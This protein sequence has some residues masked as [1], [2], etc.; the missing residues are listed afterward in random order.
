MEMK[1][2]G[3]GGSAWKW[4]GYKKGSEMTPIGKSVLDLCSL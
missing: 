3:S 2:P 4:K 1:L